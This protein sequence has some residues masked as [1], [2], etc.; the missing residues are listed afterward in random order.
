MDIY[1]YGYDESMGKYSRQSV[2]ELVRDPWLPLVYTGIFMLLAGALSFCCRPKTD[3]RELNMSWNF[4]IFF[5]APAILSW[6]IA[7]GGG[8]AQP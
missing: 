7:S 1:Q 4:F 3:N 2:F 5:A 8:I 6:G